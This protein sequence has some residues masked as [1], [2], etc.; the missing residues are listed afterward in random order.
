MLVIISSTME[1]LGFFDAFKG[2]KIP[3]YENMANGFPTENGL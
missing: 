3:A 2:W 1:H